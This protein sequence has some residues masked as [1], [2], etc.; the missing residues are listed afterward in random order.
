MKFKLNDYVLWKNKSSGRIVEIKVESL[1]SYPEEKTILIEQPTG[2]RYWV[3]EKDIIN[4]QQ[5]IRDNKI[6]IIL[7]D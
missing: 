2:Y 1:N 4:D 7:E 3:Y 5:R 6:N